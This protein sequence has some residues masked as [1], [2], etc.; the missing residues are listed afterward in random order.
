M[1]EWMIERSLMAE[2]DFRV[3]GSN[4]SRV[5]GFSDAAFAFAITLL[6]VSL[7]IPRDF[8]QLL[9]VLRGIPAFAVCF[10]ILT[11]LWVAH[12]KFFRRFGLEDRLTIALNSVLLFVVMVY[13]YPL[14]FVFTI[15]MGMV[16]GVQPRNTGSIRVDQVGDL[17][18][19]YGI[20]FIAVFTVLGLMNLRA[21]RLRK[22]LELDELEQL[23]TTAELVRCFGIAGV[24]VL[25]VVAALVIPGGAAG[26]A[27]IIYCLIGAVE[28]VV[29]WRFGSRV[30][31]L[32]IEMG[33]RDRRY[34][35]RPGTT[36]S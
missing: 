32:R 21:Y 28:Y 7:E 2:K 22:Q 13:V 33:T 15:F 16:T 6:V 5:E 11:W 18:V 31:Q 4:V 1:R 3:R 17:F 30:E 12:F 27:G 9:D 20:G 23:I 19:I 29:G 25:S 8:D 26:I 10:A 24:G 34:G 14:K 36:G 35:G